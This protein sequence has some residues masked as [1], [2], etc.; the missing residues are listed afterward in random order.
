[1]PSNLADCFATTPL[2]LTP[3]LL[4]ADWSRATD[5]DT[6]LTTRPEPAITHWSATNRSWPIRRKTGSG[7]PPDTTASIDPMAESRPTS[8]RHGVRATTPACS[9][10][11]MRSRAYPTRPI[12]IDRETAGSSAWPSLPLRA[13]QRRTRQ[14]RPRPVSGGNRDLLFDQRRV[15]NGQCDANQDRLTLRILRNHDCNH[16][17]VGTGGRKLLHPRTL[18]A[19]ACRHPRRALRGSAAP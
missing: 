14:R 5:H 17:W 7:Q 16:A 3:R 9:A 8:T 1:M 19:S 10:Q 15:R 13:K 6:E 2:G 11:Q 12:S 4:A 18:S